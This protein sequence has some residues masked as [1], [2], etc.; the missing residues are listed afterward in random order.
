MLIQMRPMTYPVKTFSLSC[1]NSL[2]PHQ[3]TWVNFA[4]RAVLV[5]DVNRPT[6]DLSRAACPA[7]ATVTLKRA[8]S[9][10]AVA[11][12]STTRWARTASA[13]LRAFTVSPCADVPTIAALVRVP[14]AGFAWRILMA[15]SSARPV[16]RAILDHDVATARVG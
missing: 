10:R 11:S 16:P 12:A 13:A 14:K 4:S 15:K 5:S 2:P 7:I 9:T 6:A 1:A 8:T 3:V